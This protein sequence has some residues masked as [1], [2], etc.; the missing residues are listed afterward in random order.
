MIVHATLTTKLIAAF[1][2]A[3][4]GLITNHE[5]NVWELHHKYLKPIAQT[6]SVDA[7]YVK[8][9]PADRLEIKRKQ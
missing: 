5:Y 4:L 8:K 1:I 3:I 7:K 9:K 2:I 6:Q